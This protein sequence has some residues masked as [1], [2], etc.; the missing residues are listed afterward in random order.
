[1]PVNKAS[2]KR[3]VVRKTATRHVYRDKLTVLREA[4]HPGVAAVRG[5][6]TDKAG[7]RTTM[8]WQLISDNAAAHLPTEQVFTERYAP[9]RQAVFFRFRAWK[10]L[11]G[12]TN[13][14]KRARAILRRVKELLDL[15]E[16][17]NPDNPDRID[18]G[19]FRLLPRTERH[20]ELLQAIVA[21]NDDCL[22]PLSDTL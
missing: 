4:K 17:N 2:L 3:H 22:L 11:T 8:P 18:N 12:K 5:Y 21:D 7:N 15:P 19:V 16:L 20:L 13:G 14:K 6:V 1:M 10:T 9:M